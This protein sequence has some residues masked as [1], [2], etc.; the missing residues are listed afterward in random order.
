MFKKLHMML[1]N[2][3]YKNDKEYKDIMLNILEYTYRALAIGAILFIPL[4]VIN[5]PVYIGFTILILLFLVGAIYFLLL[6]IYNKKYSEFLRENIPAEHISSEL[7]RSTVQALEHGILANREN[8]KHYYTSTTNDLRSYCRRIMGNLFD[9]K[10][11]LIGE[12]IKKIWVAENTLLWAEK[13]TQGGLLNRI[14]FLL[15]LDEKHKRTIF[16]YQSEEDIQKFLEPLKDFSVYTDRIQQDEEFRKQELEKI[17]VKTKVY[18]FTSAAQD[19]FNQSLKE[20]KYTSGFDT[21]V[22]KAVDTLLGKEKEDNFNAI[23]DEIKSRQNHSV[24]DELKNSIKTSVADRWNQDKWIKPNWQNIEVR[25]IDTSK[26]KAMTLHTDILQEDKSKKYKMKVIDRRDY[27]RYYDRYPS[28]IMPSIVSVEELVKDGFE[29]PE[30]EKYFNVTYTRGENAKDVS[31]LFKGHVLYIGYENNYE[32]FDL[33]GIA[34]GL[35]GNTFRPPT[36]WLTKELGYNPIIFAETT[37][38]RDKIN[39]Q[40]W[41]PE[42]TDYPNEAIE[43]TSSIFRKDNIDK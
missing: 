4:M 21:E 6:S 10:R 22:D 14:T 28:F 5:A 39:L 8:L 38:R 18:N 9:S 27:D 31:Y 15:S 12:D 25:N 35:R 26:I 23:M 7:W 1:I 34:G 40:L 3:L 43:F 16:I 37:E 32:M 20:N 13:L 42:D 17:G 19:H 11:E 41:V 30:N 2:R 33:S 36:K 29:V 24:N